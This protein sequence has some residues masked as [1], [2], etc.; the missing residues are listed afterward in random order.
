MSKYHSLRAT[1][2]YFDGIFQISRRKYDRILYYIQ[3]GT[4]YINYDDTKLS[5]EESNRRKY[6]LHPLFKGFNFPGCCFVITARQTDF[7][8]YSS[9]K[10]K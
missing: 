8:F 9:Q 3:Q 1:L 5:C 4:C 6:V 10:I 2:N 7:L